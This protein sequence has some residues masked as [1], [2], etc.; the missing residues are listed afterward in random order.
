MIQKNIISEIY[1]LY[2]RELY[3][4]IFRF[5]QSREESEDILQDTFQNLLSYAEKHEIDETRARAF[6]Y[7][8]AHNLC[9]NK[10]NRHSK[11]KF[12]PV[13]D[14][15]NVSGKDNPEEKLETQE[16]ESKIYELLKKSDP[17]TRSIFIMKKEQNM[18][19]EE[20]AEY[21]GKSVRTVRRRLQDV[22]SYMH[23]ALKEGGFIL[24]FL[25]FK[26]AQIVNTI[27]L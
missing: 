4:Y 23:T 20:I 21:T 25:I 9:I 10:K 6:L 1:E 18:E 15:G 22:L 16:L 7:R 3:I 2:N 19:V 13:E 8:I 14:A 5:T 11:I 26:M 17:L 24:F 27:V 12:T